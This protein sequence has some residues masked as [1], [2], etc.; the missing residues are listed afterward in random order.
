MNNNP[1]YVCRGLV[2]L[3]LILFLCAGHAYRVNA[4]RLQDDPTKRS[5]Y[6]GAIW[7][8]PITWPV[9]LF[10]SLT[11]FILRVF[12]YMFVLVLFTIGLVAVRKPFLF[13]W[14]DKIALKIG[15]KLLEANT[16]LIKLVFGKKTKNPQTP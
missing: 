1:V 2:L 3:M 13:V 8:A 6:F 12:V 16:F 4:R 11:I 15:N 14:L 9:F 7:L 5:F 10:A